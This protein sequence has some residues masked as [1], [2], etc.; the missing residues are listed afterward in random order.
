[1]LARRTRLAFLD[2]DAAVK[3]LPRVVAIMAEE[4]AWSPA[5]QRKQAAG[6][7]EFMRSLGPTSSYT[8]L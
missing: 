8:A 6:A 2:I 4:L 5:E 3:A 7:L 1:M